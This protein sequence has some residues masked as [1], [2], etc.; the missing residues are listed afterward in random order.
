MCDWIEN[1][2]RNRCTKIKKTTSDN[3]ARDALNETDAVRAVPVQ[4]VVEKA[5]VNVE[6]IK[7]EKTD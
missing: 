5:E 1:A 3:E 7:A 6:E 2:D 4:E